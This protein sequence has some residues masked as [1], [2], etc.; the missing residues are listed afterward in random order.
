[1]IACMRSG[2]PGGASQAA[3]TPPSTRAVLVRYAIA[4]AVA[5]ALIVVGGFFVLRSVALDE[6][7][8]DTRARVIESGQLVESVITDGLLTG[9][10]EALRPIDD[11]VLG[12]VL[13]DAVVRVKIWSPDGT[14]LYSDDPDQIGSRFALSAEQV[15]LLREGGAEVEV[16]DLGGAENERER[17]Q[18]RLIEAYTGIRTPSGEPVLFEIYEQLDS[19]DASARR[20]LGEL[21]PTILGAIALLVLIQV[22]L[23]WSLIRGLEHASEEREALL[24]NAIGSSNRERRR[25]AAYLHDGPVQ[26]IAGVAFSLA[27][28]ADLA[29]ARGEVD[30]ASVL[31]SAI[32]NLRHS[33]RDLRALLIDLHPQHL[34]AAGL[35]AGLRDLLSPLDA[36]EIEVELSV[37]GQDRIDQAQEALVY[38]TAQEA[39]RN[40]VDHAAAT[41]V[42]V[43]VSGDVGVA[44]LVVVDNGL[45]F[46]EGQRARRSSEGH[47]GLSLL[48]EVARQSGAEL[49]INS[50]PGEGTTVELEVPTR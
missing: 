31:T 5:T 36:R 41:R 12:R 30:E 10:A 47:L 11:V 9:D 8:L 17:S 35:E 13:S 23:V 7:R 19:V 20:L 25:V 26:D 34:Q 18:G 46:T 2:S 45:G 16:S 14:V 4:T 28:V 6:A 15:R 38:R 22:P 3:T 39:L 43:H 42:S 50:S 44:R 40:V 1:M 29:R 48:E 32:D 33:V 27:P 24:A 37:A 21:A 49:R